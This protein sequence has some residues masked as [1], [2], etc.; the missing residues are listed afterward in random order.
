MPFAK[1]SQGSNPCPGT[2]QCPAR[3]ASTLDMLA[4]MVECALRADTVTEQGRRP[5]PDVLLQSH[6][7]TVVFPHLLAETADG[8]DALEDAYLAGERARLLRRPAREKGDHGQDEHADDRVR[9]R[10]AR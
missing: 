7:R 9:D 5:A 2:T 3:R 4:K 8:E 6:P 10:D 1:A